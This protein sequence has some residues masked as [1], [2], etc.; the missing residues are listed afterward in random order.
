MVYIV[1]WQ[2]YQEAAENLYAKSPNKVCLFD[3]YLRLTLM[4]YPQARYCVKWRSSEGKL[5]LKITDDTTVCRYLIYFWTHILHISAVHQVQN[6]LLDLPQSI[7]S[8]ES[9]A[10]AE[11]AE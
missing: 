3:I 11:N 6:L 1:S 10:N 2:E 8:F 5:V 7:R 9:I 4:M